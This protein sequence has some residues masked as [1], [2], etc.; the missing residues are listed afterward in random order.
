MVLS[1]ARHSR[2]FLRAGLHPGT[3]WISRGFIIILWVWPFGRVLEA[4]QSLR[5]ALEV[6]ALV[7]GVAT[8]IYTGILIGGVVSR[9]SCHDN[10]TSTDCAS[11]LQK[12]LLPYGP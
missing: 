1:S 4:D 9:P 10:T 8:C 6:I 7:F 3:S 5:T 2:K 12:G 11:F